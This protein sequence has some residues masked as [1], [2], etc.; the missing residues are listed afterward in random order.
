MR[1]TRN[2]LTVIAVALLALAPADAYAKR[3]GGDKDEGSTQQSGKKQ[4]NE[5]VSKVRNA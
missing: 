3:P 5:L 2:G 1:S 4:G